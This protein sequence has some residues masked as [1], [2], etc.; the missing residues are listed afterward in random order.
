L[1]DTQRKIFVNINIQYPDFVELITI[2][3]NLYLKKINRNTLF[4]LDKHNEIVIKYL[5]EWVTGQIQR[6][7]I[8]FIGGYGVGKTV[9]MNAFIQ[10]LE[11]FQQYTTRN[12][13]AKF[14]AV[15][16]HNNFIDDEKI[17]KYKIVFINDLMKEIPVIK[18]FGTDHEP[19]KRMLINADEKGYFVF[20]TSNNTRETMIKH[21][22]GTLSD[23]IDSLFT[24]IE[25]KGN[26]RR[27]NN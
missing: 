5:H 4:V 11:I 20:I 26:S 17:M 10:T 19:I 7:G 6:K 27:K 22:G 24:F 16:F 13:V 3:A 12:Y 21:Y 8:A 18:I 2:Q 23:R 15:D 9:L 1:A 14:E 25:F